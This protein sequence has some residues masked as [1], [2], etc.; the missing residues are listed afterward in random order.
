MP[1]T[2]GRPN[3]LVVYSDDTD[4]ELLGC[5]G[6]EGLTPTVDR[7]ADEG[8]R[9]DGY[10]SA[11]P[12][13][14]PSRHCALTGQYASRSA[15]TL[16]EYPPG[17]VPNVL[18]ESGVFREPEHHN[19]AAELSAAGYA[20]GM[21]GKWHQ[22]IDHDRFEPVAGDADPRDPEVAA[23]L[24]DNYDVVRES[25]RSTG[26]DY[27]ESVYYDN[28]R[29]MAIPR[30]LRTHNMDWV[31]QGALDFLDAHGTGEDPFFL[32]MAP[33]CTHA[34]FGAEQLD[35]DPRATPSGYLDDAPDVQ[36]NR[37]RVKERVR[38]AD[39]GA[40]GRDW[41]ATWMDDG[42]AAVL[43]RLDELG[44]AEDTLVIYTTD[45]GD[46]RGKGTVYE[47]GSRVP[48]V[49]RWPGTI[50][51]GRPCTRLASNVDLAP[52]VFDVAGVDPGHDHTV[53][54]RSFA[55]L[56]TGEGEYRRESVYQEAGSMRGVVTA[57]GFHYVA[58]RFP[59][60]LRG[61]V[62][63]GARYS[64]HWQRVDD[65]GEVRWGAGA[66]Y[67]AYFDRDQLYDLDADPDERRNLA[68]DPRYADVLARLRDELA[69][70][71]RDLPHAFG[72]FGG[73]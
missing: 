73:E 33:T 54:G 26:F 52:T 58:T 7:L 56:L 49:A 47:A 25:V 71:S 2:G 61:A 53:D 41:L 24:A 59:P 34:P 12:V 46:L 65:P 30:E 21:V 35:A 62:D 29:Q 51:P 14:T 11:A 5:Y 1:A 48:F 32:W 17:T 36:P 64:H 31:T 43:D 57:D 22:G 16:A 3:V 18:F 44:V 15:G 60:D 10:H 8:I 4:R 20:T 19:L 55:P 13:C 38:G 40:W 70:Y 66:D 9:F 23:R 72:E 39:A 37:E 63:D 45:H 6:G 27:A 50:E 28:P 67:P 69:A 68:D 42:I